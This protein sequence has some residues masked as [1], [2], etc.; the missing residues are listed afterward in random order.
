MWKKADLVDKWNRR[1]I[2]M[3]KTMGGLER[4]EAMAD[5]LESLIMEAKRMYY[6]TGNPI[7]DDESYDDCEDKLR[8]LRPNSPILDKVGYDMGEDK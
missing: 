1:D 5:W 6:T 2:E 8:I 7:M 3:L 4:N